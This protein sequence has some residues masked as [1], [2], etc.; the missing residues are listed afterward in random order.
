[1]YAGCDLDQLPRSVKIGTR[2]TARRSWTQSE[3]ALQA[4]YSFCGSFIPLAMWIG[5]FR[6]I[7]VRKLT[8]RP[9]SFLRGA[10]IVK[11]FAKGKLQN[12]WEC[13]RMRWT[14]GDLRDVAFA[15]AQRL[16]VPLQRRFT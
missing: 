7:D 6:F 3:L 15:I 14:S 16:G 12:C 9:Y 11:L 1:V 2:K 10:L 4:L 5:A 13:S 8:A